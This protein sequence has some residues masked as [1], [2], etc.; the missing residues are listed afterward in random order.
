MGHEM[1]LIRD[2]NRTAYQLGKTKNGLH[3]PLQSLESRRTGDLLLSDSDVLMEFLLDGILDNGNWK[4]PFNYRPFAQQ[5]AER[6]IRWGGRKPVRV[7]GEAQATQLFVRREGHYIVTDSRYVKEAPYYDVFQTLDR[8][9]QDQITN[10]SI[11]PCDLPAVRHVMSYSVSRFNRPP[12]R[13]IPTEEGFVGEPLEVRQQEFLNEMKALEPLTTNRYC[14]LF[15]CSDYGPHDHGIRDTNT[16]PEVIFCGCNCHDNPV[17][18][19]G[20]HLC[21]HEVNTMRNQQTPRPPVKAVDFDETKAFRTFH[22]PV[23]R[24][25]YPK[26]ISEDLISADPGCRELFKG[27]AKHMLEVSAAMKTEEPPQTFGHKKLLSREEIE[28]LTTKR[29]LAYRNSLYKYPEGPS[30][31]E[32]FF[33]GKDYGL[34]KSHP[35]W[36][37]AMKNVKSVLDQREHIDER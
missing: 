31:D 13:Y 28:R 7:V 35:A 1:Y 33:G 37:A 30:Y 23:I 25:P 27:V 9:V 8:A 24:K 32:Q 6:M 12:T 3:V 19:T 36:K 22:F 29:L 18:C 5:L 2:D 14:G 4:Q 26:L 17:V 15:G 21:C 11:A 16:R 20:F 10:T 34:Y